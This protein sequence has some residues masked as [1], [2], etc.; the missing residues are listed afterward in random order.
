M[1]VHIIDGSHPLAYAQRKNVMDVL[2]GLDARPELVENII[3]VV[4]KIDKM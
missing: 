3:S 1:L 4:N 2:D